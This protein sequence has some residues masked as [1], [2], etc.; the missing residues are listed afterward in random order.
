MWLAGVRDGVGDGKGG[1]CKYK[2][3]AE[4]FCG[5]ATVCVL[6]MVIITGTYEGGRIA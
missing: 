1:V 3:A 5:G 2:G 4:E 6:I